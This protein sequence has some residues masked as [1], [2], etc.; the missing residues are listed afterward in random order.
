M[1]NQ[2]NDLKEKIIKAGLTFLH[3][4]VTWNLPNLQSLLLSVAR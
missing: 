4:K 1:T 3:S 2:K